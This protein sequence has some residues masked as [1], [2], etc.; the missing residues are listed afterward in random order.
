M[1]N[2]INSVIRC[3][4]TQ[5][6]DYSSRT[7]CK[8]FWGFSLVLTGLYILLYAIAYNLTRYYS[9]FWG[10]VVFFASLVLLIEFIPTAI[11]AMV[12]RL[13]DRNHSGYWVIP[14]F[15]VPV[16]GWI[17]GAIYALF[18]PGQAQE[19]SYPR[20]SDSVRPFWKHKRFWL[21]HAAAVLVALTQFPL[22]PVTITERSHYIAQP[23]TPDGKVD[24]AKALYQK[25]EP[26]F[27]NPEENGFRHLCQ[28][29][30]A[31]IIGDVPECKSW[32]AAC[33]QLQLD[34]NLK[35]Q[36][37]KIPDFSNYL[38]ENKIDVKTLNFDKSDFIRQNSQYADIEIDSDKNAD[39]PFFQES[40][41]KD[42]YEFYE[43][44]LSTGPVWTSDQHPI[45]SQWLDDHAAE[46]DAWSKAIRA[47]VFQCPFAFKSPII[48]SLL[49]YG[50]I[51]LI[52]THIFNM[53]IRRSVG[54]GNIDQALN[55][56]E[57]LLCY[58]KRIEEGYNCL[59]TG[60]INQAIAD[61]VWSSVKTALR[62]PG[63]CESM[64][65]EQWERL[66]KLAA[67]NYLVDLKV[68]IDGELIGI[69]DALQHFVFDGSP[70]NG[71]YADVEICGNLG[72]GILS[73]LGIFIYDTIIPPYF[74]LI[75]EKI[76]RERFYQCRLRLEDACFENDRVIRDQKFKEYGELLRPY[77]SYPFPDWLTIRSRSCISAGEIFYPAA[78]FVLY[79]RDSY[80]A[81]QKLVQVAIAIERYRVKEG[82]YPVELEQLVGKYWDE[83]Q[84]GAIRFDPCSG[85][86]TLGYR[87]NEQSKEDWE[88]ELKQGLEKD[89][90]YRHKFD[91][92]RFP[93]WRSFILYS[94][95]T[96][97]KDDNGEILSL[98]SDEGDLIF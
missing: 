34:P 27:K 45:A 2:Y 36:Y 89:P 53:R 93:V 69:Y 58:A 86:N 91:D 63:F 97:L 81:T 79:S 98:T 7:S 18:L 22:S 60:V 49:H 1:L 23:R 6:G 46:L 78:D 42:V 39:D 16:I 56:M 14:C 29:Y 52:V 20:Q 43:E 37:D 12:R 68:I 88:R 55:D 73:E 94:V 84:Q 11:A 50:N 76:V 77:N 96:D 85:K 38:A 41:A 10:S 48:T 28:L 80:S 5:R 95:G 8:T 51:R 70:H 87:I 3:F 32:K 13:H 15:L 17:A 71:S 26:L 75:D 21:L 90:E 19:N 31:K 9:A 40:L 24:Y 67:Q 47:P 30:G 54:D 4:T 64:T 25:F 83:K 92:Y 61:T 57:T 33:E 74:L 44:A 66:N 72:E 65:D 59:V 35:P 62:T 82:Q